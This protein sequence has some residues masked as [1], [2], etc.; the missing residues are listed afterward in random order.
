MT[1]VQLRNA[2]TLAQPPQE[3]RG[4]ALGARIPFQA[5][6]GPAKHRFLG[7]GLA[8]F[9]TRESAEENR[10]SIHCVNCVARILF[11]GNYVS[12]MSYRA[13]SRRRR[14]R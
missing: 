5:V 14:M 2:N 7:N 9:G 8:A 10:N 4:P 1:G 3:T 13:A 11:Q 6:S 12:I